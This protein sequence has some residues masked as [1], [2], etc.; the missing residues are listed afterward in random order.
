MPAP[1]YTNEAAMQLATELQTALIA[2]TLDLFQD[3][4][5]GLSR[6]TTQ[7]EL[8][9]AVATFSGYAQAAI[10]ATLPP[11]LDPAGGA[12][13][14][15]ATPQFNHSGGVVSNMIRGFWMEDAG[16]IVRLAGQFDA[17]IPM[18]ALGDAIPIDV[19]YRFSN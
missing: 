2:S 19:K 8:A 12:S 5:V 4:L 16:G 15:I 9:A 13:L 14:Q 3:T 10:A 17:D 1:I 18:A 11:Y 6:T 7:A